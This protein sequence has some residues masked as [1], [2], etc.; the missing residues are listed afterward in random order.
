MN[1]SISQKPHIR[2]L[3]LL[4]LTIG[5]PLTIA[6]LFAN[7]ISQIEDIVRSSGLFGPLISIFLFILF[8]FT[9]LP[10]EPLAVMNGIIFGP[11]EGSILNLV[12]NSAAS[13]IEYYVGTRMGQAG[14]LES[15]LSKLPTPLMKFA[16]TSLWFLIGFR[17]I[18]QVGGKIVS[19]GAGI[20]QVPL[21]RY[22][23][24]SIIANS[25]GSLLLAFTG[26]GILHI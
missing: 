9:P 12:G 24:T 11:L 26:F 13:I 4:I 23:W 2:N 18:P 3:I 14:N 7:D 16:P 15:P 22:L 19:F 25:I 17:F 20:F 10:A 6:F 21:R 1:F 8:G 5:L